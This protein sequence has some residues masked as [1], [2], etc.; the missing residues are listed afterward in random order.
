MKIVLLGEEAAG[1]QT[2]RMLCAG[3][4]QVAQVLTSPPGARGGRSE[5]WK[6]AEHQGCKVLPAKVIRHPDMA[7]R[8]REERIDLLLNIHSLF[9]LPDP[10]LEAP[11]LG[12][13]NLHPAPLPRY[14]GLNSVSWAI[15]RGEHKH[16]VTLHKMV[17]EIDAG[18]I[19]G[20]EFVTIGDDEP[21]ISVFVRCIKQGLRLVSTLLEIGERMPAKI[22][23]HAQDLSQRRY[24]GAQVPNEGY[25]SWSWSARDIVN[26]VRACDFLPFP[27][28]WGHPRTRLNGKEL[29]ILKANCTGE[30]SNCWPGTVGKPTEGG[31][32]V[33]SSDEWVLLSCVQIGEQPVKPAEILATGLR[34][35]DVPLQGIPQAA[36]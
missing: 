35:E 10:V 16:G 29:S 7:K 32:P 21:A 33:A 9:I 13:F 15:Y 17:H 4:H 3:P 20:R 36:G 27:S 28:A 12:C 31:V 14:A 2:L 24:F 1:V 6:A 22:P 25:L 26:F 8:I 11:R 30:P 5:L 18:P 34:L 23:L 19:V